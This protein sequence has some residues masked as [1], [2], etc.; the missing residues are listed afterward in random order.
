MDVQCRIVSSISSNFFRKAFRNWSLSQNFA[1]N[2]RD[3][4][5]E[6]HR[7]IYANSAIGRRFNFQM[8]IGF[9][10]DRES[11]NFDCLKSLIL[12]LEC[13]VEFLLFSVLL[14]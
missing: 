14:S 4:I 5:A 2:F 3:L 12:V 7:K 1:N 10:L 6:V 9:F 13:F 8:E 11:L